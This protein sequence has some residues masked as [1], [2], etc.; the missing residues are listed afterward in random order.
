MC[1][2]PTNRGNV[3]RMSTSIF[4]DDGDDDILYSIPN[5]FSKT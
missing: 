2:H 3:I 4:Y 1:N 5:L